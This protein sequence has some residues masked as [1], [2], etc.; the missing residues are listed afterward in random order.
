[1]NRRSFLKGAAAGIGLIAATA[2]GCKSIEP[3]K[4][5]KLEAPKTERRFDHDLDA[6]RYAALQALRHDMETAF[7][8]GPQKKTCSGL[9]NFVVSQCV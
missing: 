7:L 5:I 2:T 3:P 8:F 6:A 9:P 4:K 1:M